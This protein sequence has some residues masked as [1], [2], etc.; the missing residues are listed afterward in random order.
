LRPGGGVFVMQQA[1]YLH[2]PCKSKK[3]RL[4]HVLDSV[5][6][7]ISLILS[8]KDIIEAIPVAR[9]FIPLPIWQNNHSRSPYSATQSIAVMSCFIEN[10]SPPSLKLTLEVGG[11][12][13]FDIVMDDQK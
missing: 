4:Q 11:N 6:K 2:K 3:L 8:R 1:I 12:V 7:G 13:F 10:T 9:G 5:S